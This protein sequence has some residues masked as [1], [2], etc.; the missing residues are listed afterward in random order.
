MEALVEAA[1]EDSGNWVPRAL[2]YHM[3]HSKRPCSQGRVSQVLGILSDL[4][5]IESRK[6]GRCMFYRISSRC[7]GMD[8]DQAYDEYRKARSSARQSR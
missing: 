6:E 2:I 5:I 1:A 4:G 3:V 7:S 8:A